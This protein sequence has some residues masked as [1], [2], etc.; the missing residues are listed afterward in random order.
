MSKRDKVRNKIDEK[1]GEVKEWV[2]EHTD[3]PRLANKGRREQLWANARQA[4]EHVK[5]AARDAAQH[6]RDA[7]RDAKNAAHRHRD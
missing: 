2:G 6:L 1:I 3:N 4:R 5:D 7:A